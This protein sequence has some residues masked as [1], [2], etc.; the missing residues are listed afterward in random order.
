MYYL[1]YKSDS[2][3]DLN[4][5]HLYK[6]LEKSRIYNK[7]V[8]ISGILVC[9]NEDIHPDLING[10]F[11]QFLEG[12]K[13]EIDKLMEKI[14]KNK[15]HQNV[16]IIS[17][18]RSLKRYF[19]N[20][21]MGLRNLNLLQYKSLLKEFNLRNIDLNDKITQDDLISLIQ[22]LKVFYNSTN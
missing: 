17:E 19:Q 20:W 11:I 16:E 6:I 9:I 1:I 22:M 13:K 18:G 4:K 10:V 3:K 15:L 7:S 21:N 12:D 2:I 14:R 8:G 5:E